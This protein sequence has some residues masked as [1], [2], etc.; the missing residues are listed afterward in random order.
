L[1][2]FTASILTEVC[3]DV[4]VEPPLQPLTGETLRFATANRE[5]EARVDVAATE[6]WG[7]KHQKAF[8]DVKVFNANASSYCGTQV[9]SLYRR[10]NVRS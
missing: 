5:D 3:D 6:F 1:R 4:R 7:C 2:D 9:L 8:F 10:L